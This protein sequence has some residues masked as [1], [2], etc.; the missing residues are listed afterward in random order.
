MFFSQVGTEL[1]LPG[2]YQYF[3]GVECLAQGLAMESDALPL[4]HRTPHAYLTITYG[5]FSLFLHT[6]YVFDAH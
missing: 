6:N 2:Y 5:K 3:W 4:N 1:P